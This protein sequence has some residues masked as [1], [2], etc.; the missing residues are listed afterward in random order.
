MAKMK[1]ST[2]L[3]IDTKYDLKINDIEKEVVVKMTRLQIMEFAELIRNSLSDTQK[4]LKYNVLKLKEEDKIFKE[5]LNDFI[6][7]LLNEIENVSEVEKQK[8][9]FLPKSFTDKI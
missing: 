9:T 4:F 5:D 6:E 1:K 3:F 7:A 2:K 8:S